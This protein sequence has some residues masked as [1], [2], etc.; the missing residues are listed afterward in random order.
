MQNI[1]NSNLHLLNGNL[2]RNRGTIISA[3]G[4]SGA[5]S[6]SIGNNNFQENDFW[7]GTALNSIIKLGISENDEGSE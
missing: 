7:N 1:T 5:T 2:T 3:E 6:I 4:I